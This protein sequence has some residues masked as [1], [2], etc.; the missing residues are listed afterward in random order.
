MSRKPIPRR[1]AWRTDDSDFI[2]VAGREV[3]MSAAYNVVRGMADNLRK[4]QEM[5]YDLTIHDG[6]SMFGGTTLSQEEFADYLND[7]I[8][9]CMDWL[10]AKRPKEVPLGRSAQVVESPTTTH[11]QE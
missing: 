8:D 11:T 1:A 7:T 5:D 2:M 4:A 6:K 3:H 10:D 9:Q